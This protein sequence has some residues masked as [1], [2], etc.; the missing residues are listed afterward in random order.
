MDIISRAAEYFAHMTAF[1]AV[2][3]VI[4]FVG[5][6]MLFISFQQKQNKKIY[7]WQILGVSLFTV[8]FAM[9]GA[10]T[11][12]LLNVLGVLRAAV[13][14][15]SE[16]KWARS[17]LWV[18]GLLAAYVVVGILIWEDW[19]SLL[20][21]LAM[22]LSTFAFTA[23][24]PF[25]FRLLSFP[26]SPMWLTYNIHHF[27]ISGSIA[28]CCSMTSMIIAFIRCDLLPAIREKRG[29]SL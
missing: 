12:A 8:H 10:Y 15:N 24:T 19:Y 26:C 7:F 27:S 11:G 21:I 3:Q 13:F 20:P 5:M 29:K 1:E 17:K 28:E 22:I 23:K 18:W 16:R 9:L 6:A 4:G 25:R 2:G 14:Y